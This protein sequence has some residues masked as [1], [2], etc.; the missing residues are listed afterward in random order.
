M[1]HV[2]SGFFFHSKKAWEVY[3]GKKLHVQHPSRRIFRQNN[4]LDA[5]TTS[6]PTANPAA[7]NAGIHPPVETASINSRQ[8]WLLI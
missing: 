2:P 4:K 8:L 1:N 6:C 3:M 5:K 7:I